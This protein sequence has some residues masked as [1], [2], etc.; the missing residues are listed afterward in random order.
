MLSVFQKKIVSYAITALAVLVLA[1]FVVLAFRF[2]GMFLN[3]FYYVLFPVAVAVILSYAAE[4]AVRLLAERAKLSKK[5]ACGLCFSAI[6]L[7]AAVALVFGVPYLLSQVSEMSEALPGLFDKIVEYMSENAP[8]VKAFLAEQLGAIS[9][10]AEVKPAT[11][12]EAVAG[13]VKTAKFASVEIA[14]VASFF[15]AAAVVPIYLYYILVSE[16][17]FFDWFGERISFLPPNTR[18]NV[19]FFVRR[20]SEIMQS[21]FRGQL[22]I[23][24]IMGSMLGT[25]LLVAGVRFGFIL[26][27][28]AGLL[29]IIPYFGTMVGLGV[30]LPVAFFEAGGGTGLC[31]TAAAIFGV[32]QLVE[33]YYLTPKIM[34]HKTGLHP[35]V[36]I[37]SVFF[38]GTALNGILGMILAIPFSA[39]IVAAYPKFHEWLSGFINSRVRD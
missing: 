15:A 18:A 17:D 19:V 37:F 39:F 5:A 29:N 10:S 32:V 13:I 9:A 3:A 20:F 12:R 16:W 7:V 33:G 34:G 23:A 1:A 38:W 4:P 8:R 30:I 27:M 35:T 36:I 2:L 14:A 31:L 24:F 22:L 28:A 25:G 11:S 21:F 26:G 6:A